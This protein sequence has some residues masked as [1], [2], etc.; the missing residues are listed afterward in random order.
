MIDIP[1]GELTTGIKCESCKEV[2]YYADELVFFLGDEIVTVTERE[3]DWDRAI[4]T[5]CAEEKGLI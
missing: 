2:H 3:P 5:A 4:C 1:M